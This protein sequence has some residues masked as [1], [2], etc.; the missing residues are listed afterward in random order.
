[1]KY[2]ITNFIRCRLDITTIS[3]FFLSSI[4]LIAFS[5][6]LSFFI[7]SSSFLTNAQQ[8]PITLKDLVT[9]NRQSDYIK[10]YNIPL[11][12]RGLKGI[13]TDPQGNAWFYHSTNKSTT[14]IKLD[15]ASNKFTQYDVKGNTTVDNFIIN[16]AGGQLVFDSG[17]NILWCT[18]ARTNSIGRLDLKNNNSGGNSSKIDLINIPT[19]KSGPMG[20]A[21]S[22]DGKSVWFAEIN[23][24]KIARLD[25]ESNKILEYRT[26]QNTGPTFVTFDNKGI[27]WVTMSY[28]HNV[29]RV[30]PWALV[31]GRNSFGMSTTALPK[32]DM[33]S[34][35]G[36]AVVG[37]TEK[38][39]TPGV[40]KMF[41]SD[42]GSSRVV[43][44]AGEINSNSFQSY[45]S[46]WTSPSR[47]Y[48]TT[49]PGQIVK[50]KPEKNIYFPEHGGNRISKIS[51]GSG[52]MTEY[53]IPTGPLS[54]TLF[55]AVSDDGKRV[56]FTEWASNKV[57][58]LDMTVPV[59]FSLKIINNNNN[60]N[61]SAII[62]KANEPKTLDALLNANKKNASS[63][64]SFPLSLT[65]VELAVI[66]MSDSGL[67]GVSYAAKPQ[68]IDLGQHPANKS[69][70]NLNVEQDQARS[71]QYTVMIKA[72]ASEKKDPLLFVSLLYPITLTVDVPTTTSQQ[73]QSQQQQNSFQDN[74]QKSAF[75]FG[76][77]LLRNMIRFLALSA[78]IG[79][80]A[81]TIYRRI[82]RPKREKQGR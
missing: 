6:S 25:I 81:F 21:L 12:D 30:E 60:N 47:V 28:S 73:Q 18:D 8:L 24:D 1:M 71:G 51:I 80:I 82:K 53:D 38:T 23:G 45:T 32:P 7:P 74:S 72:S 69:Q 57:A 52:E 56:W 20:I 34:P 35:F 68:R 54:T 2:A 75:P 63:S 76:G 61:N 62:L 13:T 48:P 27:L 42:H 59:P 5:N 9:Y 17:R 64:P 46:Y 67:K 36:I 43:S 79:L 50:D 78:A 29:L 44:S 4:L 15:P 40:Q 33:L 37:P 55:I 10:E 39:T 41:V 26:G 14:I 3:F 77:E 31:P 65:E 49:L 58:Y 66:G 16:L 22:P 70:I 11:V 19:P